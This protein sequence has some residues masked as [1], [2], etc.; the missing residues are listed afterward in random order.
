MNCAN[1]DSVPQFFNGIYDES[2]QYYNGRVEVSNQDFL[3]IVLDYDKTKKEIILEQRNYFK[4]DDIV[5]F[6]G[7]N[8]EEF[9]YTISTIINEDGEK[10]DIARHPKMIVKLP[11][12][13]VVEK[14]TMMRIKIFDKKS[15]L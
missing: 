11:F 1:R 7:P 8:M 9:T 14:Y 5:E 12:D 3:G 10:I 13:M 4:I 15:V 2:C 6:I